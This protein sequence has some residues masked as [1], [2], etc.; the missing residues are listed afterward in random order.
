MSATFDPTLPTQ[1]DHIRL[2]LGDKHANPTAGAITD[3]LLQDATIDALLD[4]LGYVQA[5][6]QLADSLATEY[7]QRPDEYREAGGQGFKWSERVKSWRE[8]AS[9]ARA[10][11]IRVPGTTRLSRRGVAAGQMTAQT[12]LTDT[13]S[14]FRSD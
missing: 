4:S 1:R 2:A 9:M 10:G 7:A 6:A 5:L 3:P 14:H 13:P 12:S 8:V 11:K